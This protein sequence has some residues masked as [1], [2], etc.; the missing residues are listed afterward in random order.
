ML[1]NGKQSIDLQVE[2]L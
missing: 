2:E 1:S